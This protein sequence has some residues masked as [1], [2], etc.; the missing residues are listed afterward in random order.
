MTLDRLARGNRK[1]RMVRMERTQIWMMVN[2]AKCIRLWRR[3][4]EKRECRVW[5]SPS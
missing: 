1:E 5:R 4:R 3:L 2:D